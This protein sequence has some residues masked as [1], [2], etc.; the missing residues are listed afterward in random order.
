MRESRGTLHLSKKKSKNTKLVRLDTLVVEKGLAT[1]TGEAERIIRA[2][3]ILIN[4]VPMD[5]PG[6]RVSSSA[7]LRLRQK[8]HPYV[9]RGGLKLQAALD[10]FGLDVQDFR[11]LDVGIGTGGFTDC[12]LQYGAA[13]VTG[14]DVAYGDVAW[15]LR[16]DPRVTL[17]ERCNFRTVDIRELAPPF[18]LAV[19]DCSFISLEALLPNLSQAL[20]DTG[21]LLTLIKPQFEVKREEVGEG[22]LVSDGA[23]RDSVLER[24]KVLALDE[25]FRLTHHMDSPVPGARAGNIELLGLFE[26]RSTIP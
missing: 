14:V 2:G 5:K 7:E 9:S 18:D 22:G 4:A 3:Q 15:K 6:S 10:G 13:H 25:G 23:T 24:I 17:F 21:R 12:L 11:C 20:G 1:S 26:S 8:E 16:Q 19:V